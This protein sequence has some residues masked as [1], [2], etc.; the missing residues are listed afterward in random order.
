MSSIRYGSDVVVDVLTRLGVR[1]A[2]FNPGFAFRGI[3][4]SLVHMRPSPEIVECCHEEIAVALAHGYAKASGAPM[5]ACV[6]NIV[7][8]QH[9]S[10]AVFN[11]WC[12]RAPL[13][14]IGGTGPRDATRR[15]IWDWLH[16]ALVE[17]ELVR[18]Y[19][20]WDDEPAS[21]AAIPE[22]LAR[23]HR[24]AC[25]RPAGPVYVNFDVTLQEETVPTG[26]APP[27]LSGY[28]APPAP[29]VPADELERLARRL[30]EAR[31]PVIVADRVEDPN[32]VA[33]LAEA[34]GA[35]VLV[36]GYGHRLGLPTDHPL[37]VT[38][39]EAEVLEA[40]DFVLAL[41]VRDLY[42]VLYRDLAGADAGP[43]RSRPCV[44]RIGLDDLAVKGWIQDYQRLTPIDVPLT[45]DADR[46]AQDLARLVDGRVDAAER[47]SRSRLAAALHAHIRAVWGGEADRAQRAAGP[48]HPAA[49]AAAV[50]QVL[51]GRPF[52]L[53]N[54]S[55]HG[56]VRRLWHITNRAQHL[57]ESGG[58]GLGYGLGAAAGAALAHRGREVTI[59]DLQADGDL[60]YT[61]AALWTIAKYELPV[62]IVMDNNRSYFNS[63]NH[64]RIVAGHRRRTVGNEALG[65]AIDGPPVDFAGLARSFGVWAE[66]M[67][68]APADLPAALGRALEIVRKGRPALVDVLTEGAV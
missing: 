19:V 59:V 11:A 23:A 51:K 24:I 36:C 58:G 35:P 8:L 40:A 33:R 34:L 16:T 57:G 21:L 46:A 18:D 41:E 4:D 63:Y 37:N 20:K 28:A 42:G 29:T 13:M 68:E 38:G 15:R 39:C 47:D 7:G 30:C 31:A 50:W 64:A 61:P 65:T 26:Y 43:A 2:A 55:S 32:A 62:L 9:A 45:G 49:L 52:C 56:W 54:D 25:S 53:A 3:H 10:M 22:S 27:S 66:G 44:C 17:G 6:H 60:L 67:V 5:A 14:L 1:Y 12:D 48:V